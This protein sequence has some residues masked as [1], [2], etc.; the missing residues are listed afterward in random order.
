MTDI[1]IERI[2]VALKHPSYTEVMRG[3]AYHDH[4]IVEGEHGTWRWK[5]YPE[6]EKEIMDA[7]GANDLNEV[8]GECQADGKHSGKNDQLIRELYRCMGYSLSGYW[9]IFYWIEN[10][11]DAYKWD[12]WNQDDLNSM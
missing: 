1:V 12:P 11:E 3:E 7:L 2:F 6:R 5:A 8:F 9:E 4:I 10:N